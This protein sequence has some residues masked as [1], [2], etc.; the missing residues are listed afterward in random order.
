MK[1]LRI[2]INDLNKSMKKLS[3]LFLLLIIAPIMVSIMESAIFIKPYNGESTISKFNAVIVDKDK[4]GYGNALAEVFKGNDLK[5]IVNI[6]QREEENGIEDEL[7]ND[8]ISAA[9]IIPG[10][11][12]DSIKKGV[13]E[14]LTVL[15]APGEQVK[16][17]VIEGTVKAFTQQLS[18]KGRKVNHVDTIEAVSPRKVQVNQHYFSVMLA[19][20]MIFG[21]FICGNDIIEERQE[22][23]LNRIYSTG[24]NKYIYFLSKLVNAF[25]ISFLQSLIYIIIT[26]M[27]FNVD[28]SRSYGEILIVMLSASF[29]ITGLTALGAGLIR[30]KK[31]FRIY[32]YV[33][34]MVMGI[35][36]G[37]FN[38]T[39]D[40]LPDSIARFAPFT[41]NYNVYK[42]YESL[43]LGSALSSI[44]QQVLTLFLFGVITIIAGSLLFR[45]EGAK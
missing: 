2:I 3:F 8:K 45:V 6:E 34:Y 5:D 27:I 35:F 11:F 25:I 17:G 20:F 28:W 41:F 14:K 9:V 26:S 18:L 32:I 13:P 7:Q 15:K 31:L 33:I 24:T 30:T 42:S 10:G 40:T 38:L 37:C 36:S 44:T 12:A 43:M 22:D 19:T 29:G 21:I 16:A 4:N 23:I 39:L 1:A